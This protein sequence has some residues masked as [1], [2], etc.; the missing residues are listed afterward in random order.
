MACLIR[1]VAT[2]CGVTLFASGSARLLWLPQPRLRLGWVLARPRHTTET[3][4]T[5]WWPQWR[6]AWFCRFW[7]PQLCGHPSD[8]SRGGFGKLVR[9]PPCMARAGTRSHHML[10]HERS[11]PLMAGVLLCL[12][13][14][15]VTGHLFADAAYARAMFELRRLDVGIPLREAGSLFH[16]SV[17]VKV[18]CSPKCHTRHW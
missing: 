13:V 2:A 3:I 9:G 15:Q 4:P 6:W 8:T 12:V 1:A 11:A 18:R 10:R 5:W 16:V 17:K 14:S 7:W